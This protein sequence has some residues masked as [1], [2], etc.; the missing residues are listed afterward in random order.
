MAV[1]LVVGVGWVGVW[2][3]AL[4]RSDRAFLEAL[5]SLTGHRQAEPQA[6]AKTD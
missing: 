2:G 3:V 4:L 6:R 5:R 1:H